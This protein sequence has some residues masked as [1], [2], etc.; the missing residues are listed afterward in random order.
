M[1][2]FLRARGSGVDLYFAPRMPLLTGAVAASLRPSTFELRLGRQ[3]IHRFLQAQ[4][5]L[6][7]SDHFFRS[8]PWCRVLDCHLLPSLFR[9]A[10]RAPAACPW[11]RSST[12]WTVTPA[13][14][15]ADRR[16]Y[17]LA[18]WLPKLSIA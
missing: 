8:S 15:K 14:P 17:P 7:E 10:I 18:S 4:N 16:S 5:F 9:G 2:S 12:C 13:M 11:R 1:Y 3:S 6:H